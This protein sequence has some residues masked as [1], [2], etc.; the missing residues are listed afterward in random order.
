MTNDRPYRG[1]A[2]HYAEYRYRVHPK[3]VDKLAERLGW[4]PGT[5][6]L[7]LCTGPAHLAI[8]LG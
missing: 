1:A 7:D 5:T 3:F 4:S 6:V 8:Q 2:R